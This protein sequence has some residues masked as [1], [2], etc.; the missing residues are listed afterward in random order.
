MYQLHISV[1]EF[2]SVWRVHFA[3]SVSDEAGK[4]RPLGTAERWIEPREPMGDALVDALQATLDAC[5]ME[6]RPN[7]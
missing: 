7:R 3:F 5:K 1:Q 4:T 2:P 6:L